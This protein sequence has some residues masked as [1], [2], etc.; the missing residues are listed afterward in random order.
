VSLAAVRCHSIFPLPRRPGYDAGTSG[1]IK[2]N[3]FVV[4]TTENNLTQSLAR[5]I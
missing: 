1:D 4:W 2:E 5:W 3:R